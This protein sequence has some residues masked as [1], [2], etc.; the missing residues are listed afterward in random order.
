MSDREQEFKALMEW[1][2]ERV[3]QDN[4]TYYDNF[5]LLGDLNL[6]FD[7]PDRDIAKISNY[8]K[9]FDMQS[10]NTSNVNF[11]FLDIHPS[12][13][14]VW[15]SNARK[16]ETFDQIGLFFS[17]NRLPDHS[18]NDLAGES[19]DFNYAVFDF[20]K[21]FAKVIMKKSIGEMSSSKKKVFF[22]KFEHKVS[23]HM[24]IWIRIPLPE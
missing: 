13:D 21:L 1:I 15:R 22:A 2:I 12:Q 17:D 24:P 16:T 5:I 7:N 20:V 14:G 4:K 23:D 19:S 9:D 6:N 8:L 3:K 18:K 10:G 11:P